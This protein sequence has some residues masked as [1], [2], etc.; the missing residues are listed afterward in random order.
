MIRSGLLLALLLLS[1]IPLLG[2]G[3][4]FPPAYLNGEVFICEPHIFLPGE[5]ERIARHYYPDWVKSK[6]VKVTKPQSQVVQDDFLAAGRDAGIKEDVAK[7][8]L[9]R[10]QAA[11]VQARETGKYSPVCGAYPALREF[12]LYGQG[13]AQMVAAP[14]KTPQAWKE[15]LAL[16][17]P[18]RR[19][20][21]AWA[22]YMLG[23]LDIGV[24]LPSAAGYYKQL[25][26]Y[27]AAGGLDSLGLAY[28][29]YNSEYVYS[30][31]QRDDYPLEWLQ[32]LLQRVALGGDVHVSEVACEYLRAFFQKTYPKLQ[33]RKKELLKDP[34][35]RE[36][37]LLFVAAYNG[38][39]FPEKEISLLQDAKL[40]CADHLAW[41]AYR[42]GKYEDSL[43]FL[44]MVPDDSPVKLWLQAKFAR[45]R[46]DY[47]G[48][49]GMLRRWVSI[50]EKAKEE[51]N[52]VFPTNYYANGGRL[53][54]ASVVN[55]ELG[56]TLVHEKDF[57]EALYTFMK[58]DSW[59]D[60]ACV[61]E[62]LMPLN[63][64]VDFCN[65][66]CKDDKLDTFSGKLRYLL[67]RRLLRNYRLDDALKWFPAEK[68]KM[69]EDY[70]SLFRAGNDARKSRHD[71]AVALY[72][73]GKMARVH[74]L[75]L[76]GTEL[77]PDYAISDGDFEGCGLNDEWYKSF[78]SV[79]EY[80]ER[81][82]LARVVDRFPQRRWH[83]RDDAV[84]FWARAALLT[85]DENLRVAALYLAF[86][87]LRNARP[88]DAD[89]YYKMLCDCRPHFLAL[90]AWMDK[91]GFYV[92]D[93][94][95]CLE[96]NDATPVKENGFA[97]LLKIDPQLPDKIAA[98][99]EA[100][101]RVQDASWK[102]RASANEA[103]DA[104]AK[105]KDAM[106][107]AEKAQAAK[108]EAEKVAAEKAAALKVGADKAAPVADGKTAVVPTAKQQ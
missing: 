81:N 53:K 34:A 54:F 82:S 9:E 21:T 106:A 91:W 32:A 108:V 73:L 71:R 83:Y 72:N 100:A 29:S 41:L 51:G 20:R 62:Q 35:A 70:V 48:S 6:L 55:G 93:L 1:G 68:R 22:L 67:A 37:V 66:H 5:V 58:A 99:D 24:I 61:A 49:A 94:P 59:N 10:M 11:L 101:R 14:K 50:F 79:E 27:V 89:H 78:L 63:E 77:A 85:D 33:S 39:K 75:V 31:N 18:Q 4:D 7:Q 80:Y 45:R 17:P 69:A 30:F 92:K 2:C 60:G 95:L 103:M 97:A 47:A 56:Y 57:S 74:G 52:L 44:A 88:E 19:Y 96:I 84:G 3:P 46:G 40:L 16:P 64:L 28:A 38:N 23:N 36:I 65:N 102:A 76:L 90:R 15:L 107:A 25:R 104:A 26:E 12:D 87:S 8:L 98:A 42:A 86:R 43:L 13:V 105:A